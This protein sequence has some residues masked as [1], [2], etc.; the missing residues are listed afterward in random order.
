[1]RT[2]AW[3]VALA[4][5][6]LLLP[7]LVL[8]PPPRPAL[9]G[10]LL[11][12]AVAAEWLTVPLPRGGYQSA[13]LVVVAGALLLLGPVYMAVV[14]SLGVAVGNGLLRRRPFYTAV[15][16]SGQYIIAALAAGI[17]FGAID[18]VG[19]S[20][21]GPLYTGR[22]DITFLLAFIG[23]IVAYVLTS[24]IFVSQ[25]VAHRKALPVLGVF[26]ANIGWELV[27]NV[28][29]ASLGLILTL[30]YAGTLPAGA[31]V[32]ALPLLVVGYVLMLHTTREQAHRELEI[33]ERIVRASMTL[34]QEQF[35]QTMY[36]ELRKVLSADAFYVAIADDPGQGLTIEFL[37]DSGRRFPRQPCDQGERLRQ[38]MERGR[39]V[40]VA[41]TREELAQADSFV[42]VGQEDRRSAS[43]M[44]VPVKKGD[45]AI[46]LVSVQSYTLYAYHD[47]DLRLLEAIAGQ[48][49]TA[50]ENARLFEA[51]RRNVERL[52]ILQRLST[53]IAGSL[54]LDKVLPT[55]AEGARQAL[56]VDRCVIYIGDGQSGLKGVYAQGFPEAFAAKLHSLFR[57]RPGAVPADLRRPLVV[58]DA[59][60]DPASHETRRT[61]FGTAWSAVEPMFVPLR[62]T[63]LLPLLYRDEFLGLLAFYHE[64]VRP[65]TDDDRRLAEAIAN[66][67]AIAV[68]NATLLTQAQRRAAEV[69]LLNRLFSAVSGTLNLEELFRRTVEEVALQFAYSHVGIYR[70]VGDELV[71][72]SQVGYAQALERIP[73]N[74]GIMGRVVRTAQPV[75][76]PDVTADRDYLSADP[77]VRSEAAV[78]IIIDSEVRGVLNIEAGPERVLGQGD[79]QL[80]ETLSRQLSVAL[81][82]A[83]L[84][85]EAKRTRDE[86][87][88]LYDAAKAVSSSL[89]MESVLETLVQVPCR[90][91]GYEYGAILLVDERTGELVVEATHGY[92]PGTRG[93]RVSSGKGITG[94]VQR[95]GTSELVADVRADP[96]YI[97]VSPQAAAEL[98]VPLIRE[99]RVIGVFNVESARPGALGERDVNILTALAGYATI[100]IQNARLFAQTEH[101][102]ATDGLTGL[103]N[104]RHL[105]QAMERMLERC[106]RDERPVALI[107]LEIDNFKR[108][109]DTYGHQRG[110]EVLRIVAEM[111]RKGSRATDIVARYGGDEFMIVLPDT[112]KDTAGEIGERLRRAI[113]AYPFR[114]GENI[115]TNVTLS[116]GVAASPDDGDTVDRLVDAVDRAQYSAKRSGGNKVQNAH[117]YH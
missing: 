66:Q 8:I 29:F 117:V 80:L 40:L 61:M 81:R 82:N 92:S 74:R 105:H 67:T 95:T 11:A 98:A 36:E 77:A 59:R 64:T 4:A 91:F 34:N 24:S 37:I 38:I 58:E 115:V 41:R 7:A 51:S 42:R 57:G 3:G 19:I 94:W 46:G 108:Y 73:V 109:N 96:R 89:E 102:A 2:Y 10:I 23:A 35:F 47:N 12:L 103:F 22:A 15:F 84:Y 106:R 114:L 60:G 6:A 52:T 62:T 13:G 85:D 5:W 44:F 88:V 72:Q 70:R 18:P 112:G 100:A 28:A 63:V 99:G 104:H 30:I 68:K 116:V 17:V 111:L 93:Y 27:N 75:L 97:A 78:P 1:M 107:M 53:A 33:I 48:A 31:V 26:F 69:D 79:L 83:T 90:A 14:T 49:A 39:P 76:L 9:F 50:I 110:D 56:A 20:L 65:Y 55:I 86:L 21:G 43:L 54:E 16:N 32:L 101:L 25:M 87:S 71:L 113:E 45:Q